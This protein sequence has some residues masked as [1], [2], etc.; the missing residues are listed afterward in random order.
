MCLG[1]SSSSRGLLHSLSILL[2]MFGL[3][4]CR[5]QF[6][7]YPV[8]PL[9]YVGLAARELAR[10]SS[11]SISRPKELL[12]HALHLL[13]EHVLELETHLLGKGHY[14][15]VEKITALYLV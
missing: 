15:L 10:P 14:A 3:D 11:S 13:K 4:E 12:L 6:R 7:E 9:E 1:L 8:M 5:E 2:G